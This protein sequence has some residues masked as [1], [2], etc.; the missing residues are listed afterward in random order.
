MCLTGIQD[1][2]QNTHLCC[3]F[4]NFFIF[5]K[6]EV[7]IPADAVRLPR[8]QLKVLS[9]LERVFQPTQAPITNNLLRRKCGIYPSRSRVNPVLTQV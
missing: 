7:R 6:G 5:V 3:I 2:V 4:W 1:V 9:K 8:T